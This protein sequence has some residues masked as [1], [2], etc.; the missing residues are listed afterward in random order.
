MGL[1][2][3]SFNV[4]GLRETK[5]RE[6]VFQWL[7]EQN[8]AIV[9]LQE[10]HCSMHEL[11]LWTKEWEGKAYWSNGSS[12]SKGVACLIQPK[13]DINVQN[14]VTDF[15]G[16]YLNLDIAFDETKISLFI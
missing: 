2:I 15:N 8:C 14:S 11:D 13:L 16:R 3:I 4:N 9:L 12:S 10:T 7:R 5:K 1:N 6:G